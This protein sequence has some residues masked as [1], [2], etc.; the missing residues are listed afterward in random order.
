MA[1]ELENTHLEYLTLLSPAQ[2]AKPATD[3]TRAATSAS[4]P[5]ATAVGRARHSVR[6]AFPPHAPRNCGDCGQRHPSTPATL[7]ER[8][9]RVR[10][11]PL[12]GVQPWLPL[13]KSHDPKIFFRKISVCAI[14]HEVCDPIH[15]EDM[16]RKPKPSVGSALSPGPPPCNTIGLQSNLAR[17]IARCTKVRRVAPGCTNSARPLRSPT[18]PLRR[19]LP[20]KA[21]P[22]RTSDCLGKPRPKT[23]DRFGDLSPNPNQGLLL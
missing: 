3:T 21:G 9:G 5:P 11:Q 14:P 8:V 7:S 22:P 10:A 17:N 12:C 6:A 20:G 15:N 23:P 2:R 19:L 13:H 4:R 18:Y 1:P 16:Y